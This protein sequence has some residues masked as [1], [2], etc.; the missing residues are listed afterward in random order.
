MVARG[1]TV[2]DTC[3]HGTAHLPPS[4]LRPVGSRFTSFLFS[5]TFACNSPPS[6]PS[7]IQMQQSQAEGLPRV[8]LYSRY[9]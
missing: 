1:G 3:L 9:F 5:A 2:S 4:L 8:F 6:R 7:P